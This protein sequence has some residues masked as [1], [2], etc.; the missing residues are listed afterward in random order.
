MD[1]QIQ[2]VL[3]EYASDTE[4]TFTAN[5]FVRWVYA[6]HVELAEQVG[7]ERLQEY[8]NR[9]MWSGVGRPPW[10]GTE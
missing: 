3:L 2:Q 4:R 5:N 7:A 6:K 9:Y 10:L 8:A 1:E